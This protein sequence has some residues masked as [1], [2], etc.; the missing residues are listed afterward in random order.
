MCLLLCSASYGG[1]HKVCITDLG[2]LNK[3]FSPIRPTVKHR[4]FS[5]LPKRTEYQNLQNS[6]ALFTMMGGRFTI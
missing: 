4:K 5:S 2:V 1:R 6:L 3:Y